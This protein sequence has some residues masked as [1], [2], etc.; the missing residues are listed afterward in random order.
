MHYRIMFCLALALSACSKD[1]QDN[2][3]ND[4]DP[5][6]DDIVVPLYTADLVGR[7]LQIVG[8][9]A[10]SRLALRMQ[11]GAP[12]IL[13]VDVGDDNVAEERF[14]IAQFDTI[15]IS[16]NGGAD[17]IRIDDA[18][19]PVTL[20]KP[21]TINGGAG[22]DTLIGGSGAETISGGDG[23]DSVIGGIGVDTVNLG[24]GNDSF[25]WSVGHGS[26]VLDGG[27]GDETLSF[28][29]NEDPETIGV[30]ATADHLVVDW[31]GASTDAANVEQ[32]TVEPLGGIDSV[33]IGDLSTTAVGRVSIDL[34][35]AA[36]STGDGQ[37]D[38]VALNGTGGQDTITL[39]PDAGRVLVDGPFSEVAVKG[40]EAGDGI[41]LAATGS[42]L[43]TASG[44]EGVD[45]IAVSAN[46][47]LVHIATASYS[48]SVDISGYVATDILKVDALGGADV[49]GAS[50]NLAAVV[51]LQMDGG[52]GDDELVGG[53][54]SDT[55]L[56]GPGNDHVDGN[57]GNDTVFLGEGND[58]VQWDPGDGSDTIEGQG[59]SDTLEFNCSAGA[60]IITLTA[61]GSRLLFTRNVGNII[62]DVDDLEQV[63][64]HLF[65]GTD[66]LTMNALSGTDVAELTVDL[67]VASAGDGAVDT[68]T[69]NGTPS[70][71]TFHVSTSGGAVLVDGLS[72]SVVISVPEPT[73]G[74]TLNGGAGTDIFN[75]DV[76][77][78][79]VMGVTTN[80]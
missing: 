79:A 15:V 70:V 30:S 61:N 18:N 19:G 56:G 40:Y 10:D 52:D 44:T 1:D 32:L 23:D 55:L 65:G 75:V 9:D 47:A 2:E 37:A 35:A 27:E 22:N 63:A 60:E 77:V 3:D 16:G 13:E 24:A 50:G 76:G 36:G 25:F 14:E 6:D 66:T 58:T 38:T 20:N 42:D 53:N 33:T 41:L 54:G 49:L 34:R 26:D 59:G 72:T 71:D 80:Q 73:D 69:I 12:I 46:G 48:A 67:G 57:Q 17:V 8:S 4:D 74:L 39:R 7:T 68:V 28:T 64:V 11:L 5:T 43:V 62:L 51:R 29:G 78:T 21:T 31:S 45:A